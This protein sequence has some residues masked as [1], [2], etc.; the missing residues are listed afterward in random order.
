[1]GSRGA[2]SSPSP[3]T[4]AGYSGTPL[5]K[6]LTLAPGTRIW[7]HAMPDSVRAAIDPAA[8]GLIEIDALEQDLDGAHL[9]VT[10]RA[11]LERLIGKLRRLL[12][13]AGQIWVSW[14]RR[15]PRYRPT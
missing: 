1:M 11:E 7:F 4:T 8:I 10:D 3:A 14:P 15:H 12:R 9:F 13:P 5:A 6:K 2:S